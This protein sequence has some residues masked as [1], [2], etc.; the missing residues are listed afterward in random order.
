MAG[1][2]DVHKLLNG[3]GEHGEGD[4]AFSGVDT[5]F[6]FL[7]ATDASDEIDSFT[8]SRVID[9]QKWLEEAFL[10]TGYVESADWI[11]V[12]SGCPGEGVP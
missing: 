7:G 4:G 5:F 3:G 11:G 9:S 2:R 6:E 12:G 10:E 1:V 8:G